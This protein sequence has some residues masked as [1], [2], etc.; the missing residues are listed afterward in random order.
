MFGQRA[1]GMEFNLFM[2]RSYDQEVLFWTLKCAYKVRV[3]GGSLSQ[4][5]S[6]FLIGYIGRFI[7]FDAFV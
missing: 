7:E 6:M 2:G 3:V 1:P 5:F 4:V